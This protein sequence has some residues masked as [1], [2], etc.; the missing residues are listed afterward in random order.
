[1]VTAAILLGLLVVVVIGVAALIV[2]AIAQLRGR[3]AS[4]AP[5]RSTYVPAGRDRRAL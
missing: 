3:R 4:V 2:T 5:R 1:M